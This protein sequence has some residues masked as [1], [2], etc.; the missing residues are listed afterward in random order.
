MEE[1]LTVQKVLWGEVWGGVAFQRL[2][3][4]PLGINQLY[5]S[6]YAG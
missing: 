3:N 4:T 5:R 1:V 2:P 6:T